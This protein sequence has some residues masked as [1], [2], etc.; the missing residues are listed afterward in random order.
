MA[1][2]ELKKVIDKPTFFGGS[3]DKP[4]V[5]RAESETEFRFR[6]RTAYRSLPPMIRVFVE[7][8][9]HGGTCLHVHM[10]LHLFAA[11]FMACCMTVATIGAVRLLCEGQPR[12]LIGL[13]LFAVLGAGLT[14][15]PFAL[16]AREAE[17]LLR[18]V[19]AAAPAPPEP[20]EIEQP[21]R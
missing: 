10:R 8:L 3:G 4:F 12:G 5:G 17:K 9:R 19:Y 11:V 6:R 2:L 1:A 15:V 20:P 21:Y 18:T 14:G 7:P 16:E 13:T